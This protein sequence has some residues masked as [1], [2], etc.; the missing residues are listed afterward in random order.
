MD[1]DSLL[2]PFES[3]LL[4]L[5]IND[6]L[7]VAQML[8]RD[9]RSRIL[10]DFKK[11][12]RACTRYSSVCFE[13]T[14]MRRVVMRHVIAWHEMARRNLSRDLMTYG[15]SESVTWSHDVWRMARIQFCIRAV[16]VCQSTSQFLVMWFTVLNDEMCYEREVST[17]LDAFEAVDEI[18][19]SLIFPL[20]CHTSVCVM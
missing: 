3:T 14:Q 8:L 13:L 15:A 7:L 20:L 16:I 4:S 17:L 1:I 12:I 2:F 5:R 19:V 18:M 9:S 10:R 11:W 6:I